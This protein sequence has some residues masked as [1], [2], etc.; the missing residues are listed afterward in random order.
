MVDLGDGSPPAA[1]CHETRAKRIMKK[2]AITN[3]TRVHEFIYARLIDQLSPPP[4][5]PP[6]RP[7]RWPIENTAVENHR[8]VESQKVARSTRPIFPGPVFLETRG[9]ARKKISFST[10]SPHSLHRF[11]SENQPSP[12]YAQFANNFLFFHF[13][14]SKLIHHGN[15]VVSIQFKALCFFNP[16]PTGCIRAVPFVRTDFFRR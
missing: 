1:L 3:G 6:P 4:S 2:K 10:H 12:R 14:D 11:E 5:P 8:Y 13:L 9:L 15:S 16:C 7:P